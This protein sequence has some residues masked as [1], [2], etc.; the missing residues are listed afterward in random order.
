MVLKNL[1]KNVK[2]VKKY[3]PKNSNHK[4]KFMQIREGKKIK[5]SK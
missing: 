4:K 3:P 5:Y 2:K 1:L